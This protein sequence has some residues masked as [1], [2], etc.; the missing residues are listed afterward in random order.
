MSSL[1]LST[2]KGQKNATILISQ[3]RC[4]EINLYLRLFNIK[5]NQKR[6]FH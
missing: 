4:V 6:T 3:Y 5:I 2:M 1:Y